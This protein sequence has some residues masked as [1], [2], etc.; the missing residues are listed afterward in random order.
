MDYEYD[1]PMDEKM[2]EEDVNR[3]EVKV[4]IET[5]CWKDTKSH[6]YILWFY[7]IKDFLKNPFIMNKFCFMKLIQL[8]GTKY[9][10]Q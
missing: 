2:V 6:R 7:L 3:E 4:E 9:I 8:N 10:H 5:S 1:A